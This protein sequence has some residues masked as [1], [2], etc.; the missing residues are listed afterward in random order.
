MAT[1]VLLP[2]AWLGAWSWERVRSWLAEQGHTVYALPFSGMGERAHLMDLRPPPPIGLASHTWDIVDF[3]Q[4][5]ELEEVI[6]VG[7]GYAGLPMTGAIPHVSARLRH[8]V[9]L[10]AYVPLPDR[11]RVSDLLKL[12]RT[13]PWLGLWAGRRLGKIGRSRPVPPPPLRYWGLT[14][15]DDQAWVRA[16]QT[17][18]PVR[19]LD[20]LQS[21]DVPPDSL[22]TYIWCRGNSDDLGEGFEP[23]ARYARARRWHYLELAAS[24]GCLFTAPH[25]V[26]EILARLGG[27]PLLPASVAPLSASVG[28]GVRNSTTSFTNG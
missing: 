25:M 18:W 14:D 2:D 8:C 7:H 11:R 17:G 21:L 5:H 13:P 10:D 23:F 24:H 16:H 4:M 12:R 3:L 22:V 20:G 15:P 28:S 6:L 9:Y 27:S 1:Y 26:A 19:L